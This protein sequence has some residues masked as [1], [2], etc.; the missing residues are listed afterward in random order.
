MNIDAV[1]CRT[2]PSYSEQMNV[3]VL[4]H[5]WTAISVNSSIDFFLQ[6]T[7]SEVGVKERVSEMC[8]L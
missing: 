7:D 2:L 5:H 1:A 3:F 6:L 4:Q 8:R